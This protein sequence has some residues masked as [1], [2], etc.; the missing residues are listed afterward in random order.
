MIEALF[1]LSTALLAMALPQPQPEAQAQASPT[2]LVPTA[3]IAEFGQSFNASSTL[4][5][6]E[7][8]L[9]SRSQ[10]Q[11]EG[12]GTDYQSQGCRW[13]SDHSNRQPNRHHR[14]IKV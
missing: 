5:F 9:T 10:I 4:V 11:Q 13:G 3:I 7:K 6:S 12:S 14:E 2:D 8:D 1:F